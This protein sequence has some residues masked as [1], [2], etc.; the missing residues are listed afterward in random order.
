MSE[1]TGIYVLDTSAW[2]TLIEDEAGADI[3]QGLL[4]KAR[5]GEVIVL[6]SFMSFMEVY[7][8]TLQ[9]RDRSEAQERVNLMTALPVLRVESTRALGILAAELKAAHRLSV[10]DAWIAAL[11][12]ERGA[13]L[14]HK[15]PEFEQV[16]AMVKVLKLPYKVG[17]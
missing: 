17:G 16:E 15:D 7:Y 4:E 9:E 5:A 13:T 8:I 11:A 1:A 14:V 12:K 2:L 6:V 3:V 10:A